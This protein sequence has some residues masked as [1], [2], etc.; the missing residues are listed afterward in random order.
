MTDESAQAV[1]DDA[2]LAAIQ[3]IREAAAEWGDAKAHSDQMSEHL[4]TLYNQHG[5]PGMHGLVVALARSAGVLLRLHAQ[6][7]GR[8]ASQVLDELELHKIEAAPV[9]EGQPVGHVSLAV[10]GE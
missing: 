9:R 4:M 7:T 8:D 3:V 1:F 6:A 10:V 2:E 5:S